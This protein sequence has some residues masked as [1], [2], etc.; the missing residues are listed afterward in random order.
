MDKNIQ[1][2]NNEKECLFQKTIPVIN[3]IEDNSKKFSFL[4][5]EYKDLKEIIDLQ[6]DSKNKQFFLLV[7]KRLREPENSEGKSEKV[8]EKFNK[9]SLNTTTDD[10]HDTI[11]DSKT[12]ILN[13]NNLKCINEIDS[14][15]LILE[16]INKN[17]RNKIFSKNPQHSIKRG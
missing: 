13:E 3:S 1:L 4:K 6:S 10:K 9:L 15:E 5:G 7:R 12:N 2:N 14:K 17:R 16:N 8:L 11:S